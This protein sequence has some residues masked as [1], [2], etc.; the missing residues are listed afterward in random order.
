M[1]GVRCMYCLEI[2]CGNPYPAT[3]PPDPKKTPNPWRA[4]WLMYIRARR[5]RRA[6]SGLGTLHPACLHLPTKLTKHTLSFPSPQKA[7]TKKRKEERKKERKVN[8]T[9]SRHLYSPIRPSRKSHPFPPQSP[10]VWFR[11]TTLPKVVS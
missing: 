4:G 10:D 3:R 5:A 9:P 6:S 2:P 7:G 11:L 1:Y 8:A